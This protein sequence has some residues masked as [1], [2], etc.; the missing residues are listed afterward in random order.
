MA[1][2]LVA[3]RGADQ[4]GPIGVKAFAHQQVDMAKIDIAQVDG[5]LLAF[6]TAPPRLG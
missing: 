6:D 2:D 5:D 4:I 1:L 3:N